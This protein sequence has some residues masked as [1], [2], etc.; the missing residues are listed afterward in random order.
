VLEQ[1]TISSCPIR[2]ASVIRAK[3]CCAGDWLGD[4]FCVVERAGGTEVT[5]GA[6]GDLDVD[7]AV[8]ADGDGSRGEVG[9]P[10]GGLG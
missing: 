9:P 7:R 4:E 1:S 8:D 6:D 3:S 10:T 5:G 2:C